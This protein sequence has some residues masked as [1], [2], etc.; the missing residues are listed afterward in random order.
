MSSILAG[1]HCHGSILTDRSDNLYAEIFK[2]ISDKEGIG[3]KLMGAIFNDMCLSGEISR[4]WLQSTFITILEMVHSSQ[5]G[6]YRMIS[7]TH[8]F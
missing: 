2:L 4:T 5:C 3:L 8:V 1:S 7:L 6:D